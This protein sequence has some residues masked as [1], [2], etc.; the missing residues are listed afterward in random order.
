[1][2]VFQAEGM[3]C[4]PC[5]DNKQQSNEK[6]IIN[7]VGKK[8]LGSGMRGHQ[9]KTRPF[10]QTLGRLDCQSWQL[11]DG[12]IGTSEAVSAKGQEITGWTWQEKD[13]D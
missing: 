3:M 8:A 12:Q 11:R 9:A 5:R 10:G 4:F 13:A 6:K 1:M 2:S 7:L